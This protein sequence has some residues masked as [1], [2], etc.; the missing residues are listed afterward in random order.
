MASSI[1]P[2]DYLRSRIQILRSQIAEVDEEMEDRTR[3][4]EMIMESLNGAKHAYTAAL[5]NEWALER[6]SLG[7]TFTERRQ[8][9]QQIIRGVNT[10]LFD[11]LRTYKAFL[12]SL[13][14]EKRRLEREANLLE[15]RLLSL[16]D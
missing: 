11:E 8:R 3:D 15:L 4:H 1:D 2:T 7:T 9:M 6:L 5:T 16:R 10:G 14:A 12:K 13:N